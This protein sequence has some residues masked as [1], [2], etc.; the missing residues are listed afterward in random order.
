MAGCIAIH[1]LYCDWKGCRRQNRIAIQNCIVTGGMGTGQALGAGAGR[2]G[3]W[4]SGRRALARG[5]GRRAADGR[6]RGARAAGS[7]QR[8]AGSAGRAARAAGVR[9]R[10]RAERYDTAE[11]PSH[12]TSRLP[13]TRPR[14][15]SLCSQAGPAGPV[16]VV[17]H[18]ARFSTWF[19]DSV[20]F[21]SH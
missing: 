19:F 17:V 11:G 1:M 14:A 16:L 12:Y 6:T 21:L 13:T 9:A 2:A 4:A 7:A 10:G 20:F 18:L 8:A 3:S 15:R 5:T